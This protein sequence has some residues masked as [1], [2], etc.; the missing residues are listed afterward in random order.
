M[1]PVARARGSLLTVPPPPSD[2]NDVVLTTGYPA[3]R[4]AG[5]S[6]LVSEIKCEKNLYLIDFYLGKKYI[7]TVYSTGVQCTVHVH[8]SGKA[9]VSSYLLIR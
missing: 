8:E 2:L 5:H 3:D 9:D 4:D 1:E 6:M 7:T